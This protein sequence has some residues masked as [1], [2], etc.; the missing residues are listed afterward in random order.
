VSVS[1]ATGAWSLAQDRI[2]LK[3]A[4]V[5]PFNPKNPQ[6]EIIRIYNPQARVSDYLW[7]NR[8]ELFEKGT[9]SKEAYEVLVRYETI[10]EPLY[11]DGRKGMSYDAVR[12]DGGAGQNNDAMINSMIAKEAAIMHIAKI[13]EIIDNDRL[14]KSNADDDFTDCQKLKAFSKS[15]K[16]ITEGYKEHENADEIIKSIGKNMSMFI[17]GGALKAGALLI[18][19]TAHD[20]IGKMP[21]NLKKTNNDEDKPKINH[22]SI[23]GGNA[24]DSSHEYLP[25]ESFSNDRFLEAIHV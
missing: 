13:H 5:T 4:V 11:S 22:K 2:K 14:E 10:Y 24:F 15:F 12:V 16:Y 17:Q 23:R 3:G 8:D 19:R 9:F 25:Q 6:S 18:A 20:L 21:S 1:A 7:V